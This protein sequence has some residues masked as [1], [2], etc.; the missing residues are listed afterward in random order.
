MIFQ[1]MRP[2]A[3]FRDENLTEVKMCTLLSREEAVPELDGRGPE[4]SQEEVTVSLH[5]PELYFSYHGHQLSILPPSIIFYLLAFLPL[6]PHAF[7][8]TKAFPWKV[9]PTQ[10]NFKVSGRLLPPCTLCTT[11]TFIE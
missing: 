4:K 9:Y 2:M 1:G 7:A 10:S 5:I 6:L 11:H 8:Y 3:C